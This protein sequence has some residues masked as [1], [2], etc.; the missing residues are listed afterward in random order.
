MKEKLTFRVLLKAHVQYLWYVIRHKWFVFVECLKIGVP[1]WGA[2]IHD[3][4]KFTPA[5]W[6]P[7]VLSFWGPWSYEERPTWLVESFDKAWLP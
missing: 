6:K 7:Y 5:E 1:L 4:Q 3:W 2:L